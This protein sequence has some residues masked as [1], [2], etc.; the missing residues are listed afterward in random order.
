MRRHFW[1]RTTTAALSLALAF[2]AVVVG[3]SSAQA[4]T[5]GVNNWSCKATPG[6]DPV[7]MLHGL[8]APSAINWFSKAPLIAA[9]GFCVYTPTYGVNILPGFKSMRDSAAEVSG[10]VD[11][12]LASTGA[13][14]V[15]LVGHSQGTT[16]SAYYMKFLGG[17][18]K[19]NRFAGFG[20]NFKGTSLY[21]VNKLVRAIPAITPV[22]RAVCASCDEYLPPNQ[23]LTDLN[24]GGVTVPGPKYMSIVSKYDEVVLP[25]TSGVLNEPGV[26]NVVLQDACALDLAGHITQAVDPNVTRFVLWHLNGQQTKRPT[27]VPWLIPG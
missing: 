18:T 12:V 16:V 23:F 3:A 24:A 8:G 6:K 15:N 14:K 27:C 1:K 7:I 5:S 20:S 21:G 11:K 22:L 10:I 13:T 19:V 4:A 17:D 9:D 2:S 26:T 25:Y